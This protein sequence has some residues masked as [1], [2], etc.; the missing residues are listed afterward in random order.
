MIKTI[1]P[2]VIHNSGRNKKIKTKAVE[3]R[4]EDIKSIFKVFEDLSKKEVERS[5]QIYED[6]LSWFTDSESEYTSNEPNTESIKVQPIDDSFF[7]K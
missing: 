5:K 3:Q 4:K 7:E 2:F 6:H 1:K